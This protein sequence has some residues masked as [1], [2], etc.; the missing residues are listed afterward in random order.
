MLRKWLDGKTVAQLAGVFVCI[1]AVALF[2]GLSTEVQERATIGL[3]V[4]TLWWLHQ[5]ATPGLNR[6]TTAF[7][8]TGGPLAIVAMTAVAVAGLAWARRRRAAVLLALGV[9]GAAGINVLL[10]LSFHRVR[11]ALWV[12]VVHESS[13]SFPSGHAV[14]SSAL[15]LSVIMLG[16]DTRWRWPVTVLGLA[17]ALLIGLSRVYLGVHY[18]SDVAGGWIVGC[19]WVAAV[20]AILGRR[21]RKAFLESE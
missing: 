2:I 1:A 14:A 9:G 17:Y 7:T 8:N 3:D 6:V 13:F 16:W 11:P 12:P 4:A 20:W 15:A 19:V 21:R 18:P 5:F 10:K